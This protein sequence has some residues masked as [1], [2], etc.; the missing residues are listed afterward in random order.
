VTLIIRG[1]K[2]LFS[3]NKE[4]WNSPNANM[5]GNSKLENLQKELIK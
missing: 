4:E 5:L 3:F 1:E 2:R